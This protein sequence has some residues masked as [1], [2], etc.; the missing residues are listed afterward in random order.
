MSSLHKDPRGKSPFWYCA[1]TLADGRRTF[2]STGKTKKAEAAIICQYF[3]DTEGMV[4]RGEATADTLLKSANDALKRLG[5][6][7]IKRPSAA[8]YLRDWAKSQKGETSAAI[9]E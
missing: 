7:Q 2:R 6:D 5:Q 1:F 9:I 4:S 3:V 8:E